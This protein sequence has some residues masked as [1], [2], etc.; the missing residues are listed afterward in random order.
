[1]TNPH[2][3][4]VQKIFA[5]APDK[6]R[7]IDTAAEILRRTQVGP[8]GP[9]DTLEK[10]WPQGREFLLT[11]LTT[12]ALSPDG[13]KLLGFNSPKP[14]ELK[15]ALSAFIAGSRDKLSAAKSNG[16]AEEIANVE[17]TIAR[18]IRTIISGIPYEKSVDY[19]AA[20]ANRRALNCVGAQYL[21]G[22]ILNEI[23]LT[24]LMAEVPQHSVYMLVT[25]S[26]NKVYLQDMLNPDTD[27][28]MTDKKME[29]GVVTDLTNLRTS[30]TEDG[31]LTFTIDTPEL[32]EMKQN[33][34]PIQGKQFICRAYSSE[35]GYSLQLLYN[36]SL[37]FHNPEWVVSFSKIGLSISSQY[38]PLEIR[39]GNATEILNGIEAA[40][41]HYEEALKLE[42]H[43]A[44]N[45]T[46]LARLHYQMGEY[47]KALE[48]LDA[49]STLTPEDGTL[50]DLKGRI[51]QKAGEDEQA[52]A[53]YKKAVEIDPRLLGS[54]IDLMK[55]YIIRGETQVARE[56]AEE[57]LTQTPYSEISFLHLAE[58]FEQPYPDLAEAAYKKAVE[59]NDKSKAYACVRYADYLTKTG[60]PNLADSLYEE[61]IA[62][63]PNDIYSYWKYANALRKSGRVEEARQ[64]VARALEAPYDNH[65]K[66]IQREML[67]IFEDMTEFP[68]IYQSVVFPT[69]D[70][71]FRN[72]AHTLIESGDFANA[73]RA[74]RKAIDI[75]PYGA[76]HYSQLGDILLGLNN[77]DGAVAALYKATELE[78]GQVMFANSLAKQL[79]KMD[80]KEEAATVLNRSI[81]NFIATGILDYDAPSTAADMLASIGQNEAAY[82]AFELSLNLNT[83]N[84][85]AAHIDGERLEKMGNPQLAEK[86]YRKAILIDPRYASSAERLGIMLANQ[87]KKEE[88]IKIFQLAVD[89]VT[90]DDYELTNGDSLERIAKYCLQIGEDALADKIYEKAIEISKNE[91]AIR[92]WGKELE[93][94]NPN[95]AETAYR[96]ALQ[97]NPKALG[98]IYDAAKFFAAQGK[99]ADAISLVK[100]APAK[101]DETSEAFYRKDLEKLR[102]E[103]Q[104]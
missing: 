12:D 68:K 21:G 65:R 90:G 31:V 88:G 66:L 53:A 4:D 20:M 44:A 56:I 98:I 48:Y 60:K 103:L 99:I 81:G 24:Y 13:L 18:D 33:V 93:K 75:N 38:A 19:P 71:V 43:V 3:E 23:G 29:D 6:T 51:L 8:N 16:N 25:T 5:V 97:I 96:K 89:S 72:L 45:H 37:K 67:E 47:D 100:N 30:T 42:P 80:R 94:R 101:S 62:L 52:L 46:R 84:A 27:V 91:F 14:A 28:E 86:A 87:G 69:G 92:I 63:E 73:E 7:F 57:S 50:W 76:Y 54:R 11:N 9:I 61:A 70:S 83:S 35:I 39:L 78:P 104:Q 41:P 36:L 77:I 32:D 59:L 64:L 102:A 15:T 49:A 55:L 2:I 95:L 74:C 1:M 10:V 58:Y 79:I 22:H 40:K 17:R 85:P 82:I 26:D 34:L